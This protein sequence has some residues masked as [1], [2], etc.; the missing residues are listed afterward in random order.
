MS[1]GPSV[2]Y[3]FRN[4]ASFYSKELLAPR[5]NLKLEDHLFLPARD[6]LFNIFAA[7]LFIGGRSSIR[8]LRTHHAVTTGTHLSS[9]IFVTLLLKQ[10]TLYVVSVLAP[11]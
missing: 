8:N 10:I 5:P 11:F 3:L 9:M 2:M 1:P 6:C 7:T 4:K